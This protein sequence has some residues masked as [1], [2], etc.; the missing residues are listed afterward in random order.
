VIIPVGGKKPSWLRV[1]VCA[2]GGDPT[3]LDSIIS[4]MGLCTV[5][6]EA[7]CPNMPECWSKGR[8]TFMILGDVCTRNC[9]FCNV[10]TGRPSTPEPSE[11]EKIAEAVALLKLR[12]VVI[13]SV[14]RDDLV[15]GGAEQFAKTI[16]CIRKHSPGATVEVLTPDFLNKKCAEDTIISAEPDVF[17]HNLETVPRFYGTVRKGASYKNSLA[18]LAKVKATDGNI[19]TKSGIMV[20]L[21]EELIEVEK[22]MDDLRAA[23]VDFLTIG[24][25]LQPSL[26]HH[27]VARYV[28]PNEFRSFYEI[29]M[30]KGFSVVSS[31]PLTRSSYCAEEDFQKLKRVTIAKHT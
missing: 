14:T 4:S 20:G 29:A 2:S 21:G 15:D 5:C 24:Q 16:A 26:N 23:S 11:P 7:A 17:G 6:R 10:K 8:A 18:L 12:H 3:G 27:P 19:F 1:R 13:T 30:K 22:V 31:S 9:R 25:Y 28:H